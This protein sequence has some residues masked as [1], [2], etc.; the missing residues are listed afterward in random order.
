M[1]L[2]S[3]LGRNKKDDSKR[4]NGES[5]SGKE[6]TSD[7]IEKKLYK[8][9]LQIDQPRPGNKSRAACVKEALMIVAATSKHIKVLP[10][11]DEGERS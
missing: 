10:K 2:L 5:G 8:M 3:V 11:D 6:A 1:H 7:E 4:T 9:H